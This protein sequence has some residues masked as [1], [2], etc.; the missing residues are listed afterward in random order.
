MSSRVI[1]TTLFF[2]K[3]NKLLHKEQATKRNKKPKTFDVL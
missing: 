3:E 2:D 1:P